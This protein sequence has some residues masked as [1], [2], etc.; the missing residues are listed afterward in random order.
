[1]S[2]AEPSRGHL[3]ALHLA[4]GLAFAALFGVSG[5]VAQGRTANALT[6]MLWSATAGATPITILLALYLRLAGI[7]PPIPSPGL[8]RFVA[9]LYGYATELLTRRPPRAGLASAAAIFA[10]GAVAALALAL[11]FALDKGWLTVGLALMVP[12]IA[13]ISERRP[14][15]ALRYLAAALIVMVLLRFGDQPRIL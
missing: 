1:A 6:A 3:P 12:G 2:R 11:T 14:L 13:W 5:Y 8:P 4:L 10:A 9:A 15:P 7:D